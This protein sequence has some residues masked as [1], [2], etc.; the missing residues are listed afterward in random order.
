[1]L[2][3]VQ[4]GGAAWKPVRSLGQSFQETGGGRLGGGGEGESPG[5]RRVSLVEL[6]GLEARLHEGTFSTFQAA[7]N[8]TQSHLEFG[9]SPGSWGQPSKGL[10]IC[11]S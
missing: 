7:V 8:Y 3:G 11:A 5:A 4:I 9:S 1:M 6:T 2:S 10:Q